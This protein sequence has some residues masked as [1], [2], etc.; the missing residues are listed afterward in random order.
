MMVNPPIRT[1][2]GRTLNAKRRKRQS[3][4]KRKIY[5]AGLF[6][7]IALLLIGGV[8]MAVSGDKEVTQSKQSSSSD[9][10]K[11]T[12]APYIPSGRR[13][14]VKPNSSLMKPSNSTS[15]DL[16]K[17]APEQSPPDE[18]ELPANE[19]DFDSEDTSE[20][21]VNDIDNEPN[22]IDNTINPFETFPTAI[23]L[24]PVGS[25]DV[26]LQGLSMAPNTDIVK[27]ESLLEPAMHVITKPK[28]AW[29]ISGGSKKPSKA[30]VHA[31]VFRTADNDLSWNW[32]KDI[33][34]ESVTELSNA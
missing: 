29:E 7:F 30:N 31:T 32:I 16:E 5:L 2:Q 22:P 13:V 17:A 27:I 24:P 26:I 6:G 18:P 23:N 3:K 15:L 12:S 8:F 34:P 10:P 1:D 11:T 33:K 28:A 25:D 14:D 9:T 4:S 20:G 21:N 19:P